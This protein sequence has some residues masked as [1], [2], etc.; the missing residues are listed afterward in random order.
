MILNH[1]DNV[2]VNAPR[3]I[4]TSGAPDFGMGLTGQT[5]L[6]HRFCGCALIARKARSL[7]A[8]LAVSCCLSVLAVSPGSAATGACGG[9]PTG[10]PAFTVE[11]PRPHGGAVLSAKDF[12]L[13]EGSDKNASAINR[14]LAEAKRVGARSVELA[15]GTYRCFDEPG[16]VVSGFRDFTFDGKGAVLVFRRPAEYRGQPQSEL[17]L[18]KG[19]VLADACARTELKD[20]TIDWDWEGDPLGAFVRVAAKHVDEAAPENSYVDLAFV[21]WDRHPKYPE[22][23][24]VQKISAMD[25]DRMRFRAGP[26][27]SFG[28]TEGH[29]GARNAWVKPNVLR[30][31]PGLPMEGRNQNPM[32]RFNRSPAVNLARVRQFEDGG[33]YRLLHCYYGKNGLNLNANRHL[34]VRNV[35]VW[36]CFGMAM[37]TDGPQEYTE[38]EGLRVLPPTKEELAAAYP[39]KK[40]RAR[41]VTSTS[42]GFHVARSKGF[43]RLLNCAWT[44]NNDDSINFHDRFTIAVRGGDRVLDVINRRGAEYFRVEKGAEIELRYPNFA[45]ADFRAKVVRIAGNRIYLDRDMPPQ[46]GQC[47]LVWDRTYGTDNVHIKGCLFDNSG[48][49]NILSPSNLTV[50][51]CRFHRT[52]GYPIR[53]IADYRSDLWCEGMGANNL[54]VRNCRFEDVNVLHPGWSTISSVCVT[55]TDWDVGEVDPGFVGGNLLIEKC[56]FVRP[57]GPVLD[58]QTGRDVIFR[59]CTVD[60]RG[61]DTNAWPN[62]GKIDAHG[63]EGFRTEVINVEK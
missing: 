17:I 56:A 21:D 61:V 59:D 24:P 26:G 52:N 5:S 40:F 31:W 44:L 46:R 29:F 10:C 1:G 36:S 12:G 63:I 14:A 16:V 54:V 58:L 49:R 11:R 55:P 43:Y 20:F 22:P 60:L 51:D 6:R 15:P 18:D 39:G 48:F 4:A 34:T 62:A 53:F 47:F 33:F 7:S 3:L 50:E 25:E 19:N 41:P 8:G 13:S 9:E 35:T 27:F 37:V 30:L 42:D 32:V 23:V 45:P 57:R 2:V 38:V 28:Q